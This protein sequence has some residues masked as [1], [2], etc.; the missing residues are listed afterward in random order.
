LVIKATKSNKTEIQFG[1]TET[2]VGLKSLDDMLFFNN[3]GTKTSTTNTDSLK[4][5]F[6]QAIKTSN[7]IAPKEREELIQ[8]YNEYLS[9]IKSKVK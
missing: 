3:A 7:R 2:Y 4:Q 1:T 6:L 5:Q 9:L 8:L